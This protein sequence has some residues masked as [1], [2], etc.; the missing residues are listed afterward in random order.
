MKFGVLILAALLL[1]TILAFPAK[2][3]L[4]N[5]SNIELLLDFGFDKILIGEKYLT[6]ND[7]T[8]CRFIDNDYQN[9]QYRDSNYKFKRVL[10]SINIKG[11]VYEL[12]VQLNS[13]KLNILG[14]SKDSE[15]FHA[16][17]GKSDISIN[18]RT[19]ELS[20][21][22]QS[23]NY[24]ELEFN[25]QRKFYYATARLLYSVPISEVKEITNVAKLCFQNG[26]PESSADYFFLS[27]NNFLIDWD[28][29]I[30]NSY[31][32]TLKTDLA[33]QKIIFSQNG[34]QS[35]QITYD[36][37]LFESYDRQPLKTYSVKEEDA[38]ELIVGDY[39]AQR[40][41]LYLVIGKQQTE[42]RLHAYMLVDEQPY[43]VYFH[44]NIRGIINTILTLS[45][46]AMIFLCCCGSMCN[47][48][49]AVPKRDKK[50]W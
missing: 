14:V 17:D 1:T 25:E 23:G 15:Y 20:S 22:N 42:D 35:P 4:K 5:G 8:E 3:P 49:T 26:K 13:A 47:L 28:S 34:G 18:M 7:E 46:W 11:Q 29:F 37:M 16:L 10:L 31:M 38:C 40:A 21:T 48:N 32:Y 45:F 43:E 2:I 41:G 6:C 19:G 33:S 44:I 24:F 30:S 9:G 39:F 12:P 36:H 50:I 27:D